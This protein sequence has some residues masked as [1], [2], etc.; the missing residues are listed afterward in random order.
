MM[1]VGQSSVMDSLNNA[2]QLHPKGDTTRVNLLT[3]FAHV[4][5]DF[6]L[7]QA[8]KACLEAEKIAEAIDYQLGMAH[9]YYERAWI[10]MAKSNYD[11]AISNANK[12][13]V[14]YQKLDFK[15]GE[16]FSL[17]CIGS[18]YYYQVD[19]DHA[20]EYILKSAAIDEERNDLKGMSGC[21]LNIGNI[22]ADQAKYE[23]SL[24][25]Y[26]KSMEL[27]TAVKDAYGLA[28]CL[29]NIGSV[30][31]EQ[32]NYPMALEYFKQAQAQH[33][34]LGNSTNMAIC[35]MNI[36]SIY[37]HQEKLDEALN[38]FYEALSYNKESENKRIEAALFN[39]I[40]SV[41]SKKKEYKSAL[42]YYAKSLEINREGNIGRSVASNLNN[43]AAILLVQKKYTEALAH[44]EE[45]QQI[46]EANDLKIGWCSSL[47]GIAKVYMALNNNT[48]ALEYG[49]AAKTIADD[50][51][52]LA[53]QK[54]VSE[55]LTEV[56]EN[57][58]QYDQ[59]LKL[60][61][62]FKLYS[63]S[64]FNKETI[65]KIAQIEYEYKYQKELEVFE[66]KEKKLTQKVERTN[67]EL[68][69]SQKKLLFGII[70]FL[71]ILLLAAVIIFLLRIRNVKSMNENIL[72]EQKLLRSQM[73]PHFIFNSLSVLQGMI[74][75]KEDQKASN[76]LS[77][78]SRLLRITLESSREK[79]T[80]LSQEIA[81]L[82]NYAMIQNIESNKSFTF[83]I[84]ITAPLNAAQILI[85][86]MLIQPFVEN[87]IEHAFPQKQEDKIIDVT[88]Y[89]DGQQLVCTIRDNG[90][91]IEGKINTTSSAKKSLATSISRERIKLLAKELK[92]NGAIEIVDRKVNG[93]K[94]TLV[95]LIIPCKFVS[96]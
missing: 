13:L 34:K 88:F 40:A 5:A 64:V 96:E 61:Q 19:Y 47:I 95:T 18:A 65:E 42:E 84:E 44:Y 3:Q 22:L 83:N 23:E 81:A 9:V 17:N 37:M 14:I 15:E 75:N 67:L 8:E 91:G 26:F 41:L 71:C 51:H 24:S 79:M 63:D 30:Y 62:D 50:F 2:L 12:A 57:L 32:G 43:I 85:P 54:D 69:K 16:S 35:L 72:L 89:L 53:H 36:G 33:D 45:A 20:M 82:D 86:P 74:L 48:K 59:A 31:G 73:T 93:E 76:Y 49:L 94:G 11:N 46:N 6:D 38:S 10:E 92:T 52:L 78:F 7:A 56:Y 28:K 4:S 70:L 68:E 77:K 66:S 29:G 87:A 1:V 58:G 25:Y 80:L 55:V 21:Y 90:I 27:K 39:E 60:Y